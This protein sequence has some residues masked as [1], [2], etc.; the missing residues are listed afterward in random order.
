MQINARQRPD[1]LSASLRLL[2]L[3]IGRGIPRTATTA[4]RATR[5]K[6]LAGQGVR[7]QIA[8]R[9][10]GLPKP[11]AGRYHLREPVKG[12]FAIPAGR[13]LTG[14]LRRKSGSRRVWG[15]VVGCRE[16]GPRQAAVTGARPRVSSPARNPR[17]AATWASVCRPSPR[18]G[19]TRTSLL[20]RVPLQPVI[21]GWPT[22]QAL[23]TPRSGSKPR[24]WSRI[25]RSS[26]Q[27]HTIELSRFGQI[28]LTAATGIHR[29]TPS[30]HRRSC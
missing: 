24:H 29:R 22:R 28:K 10:E 5:H 13:P 16:T 11:A 3:A 27:V 14:P 8:R 12:R 2:L 15:R 9:C 20:G 4:T 6:G 26:C 7:N 23:Q 30:P 1:L 25:S 19:A 17:H 18:P 21:L